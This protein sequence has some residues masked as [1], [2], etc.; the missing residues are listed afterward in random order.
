MS[1]R[2]EG[3]ACLVVPAK[4]DLNALPERR[5]ELHLLIARARVEQRHAEHIGKGEKPGTGQ[6]D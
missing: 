3:H 2:V 5:E 4:P 6:H 1:D